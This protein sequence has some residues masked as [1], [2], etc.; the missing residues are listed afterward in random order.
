MS[1]PALTRSL[2]ARA[3]LGALI[4][5]LVLGACSGESVPDASP[6]QGTSVTAADPSPDTAATP[7]DAATIDPNS[8][9]VVAASAVATRSRDQV[10]L[11]HA[12]SLAT[13]GSGDLPRDQIPGL[14]RR[15]SA[16]LADQIADCTVLTPPEGSPAAALAAAL[17]DYRGL[18]RELARWQPADGA[19]PPAYF[20]RLA[21]TD[22][23]WQIALR[24]LGDLAGTDLLAGLPELVMPA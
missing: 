13:T 11:L 20:D 21:T 10:L 18:A 19:L 2:A 16:D 15:A 22:R 17:S 24:D 5:P 1:L 8:P 6:T 9:F 23:R 14:A 4:G 3:L 12:M 7:G